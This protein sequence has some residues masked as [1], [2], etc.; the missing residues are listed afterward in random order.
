MSDC[1]PGGFEAGSGFGVGLVRGVL[2]IFELSFVL[3]DSSVPGMGRLSPESAHAA[4][5]KMAPMHKSGSNVF[6]T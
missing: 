5:L 3:V 6:M 2:L 4:R 1:G